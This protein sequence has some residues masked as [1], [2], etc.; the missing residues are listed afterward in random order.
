MFVSI[1]CKS[2]WED[3]GIHNLQPSQ[4]RKL[5]LR[6][7]QNLSKGHWLESTCRLAYFMGPEASTLDPVQTTQN[8]KTG[9]GR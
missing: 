4:M 8:Q 3:L 2:L 9:T 7:F 1:L 6:E 5:D